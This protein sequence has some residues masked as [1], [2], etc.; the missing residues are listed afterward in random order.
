MPSPR[1]LGLGKKP[2]SMNDPR[3]QNQKSSSGRSS[4]SSPSSSLESESD[5]D[6]EQKIPLMSKQR[7]R[8]FRHWVY[9]RNITSEMRNK[10]YS[11]LREI[12]RL[13]I[14][15]QTTG[16]ITR[17]VPLR[18]ESAVETHRDL[19]MRLDG[20]SSCAVDMAHLA[21]AKNLNKKKRFTHFCGEVPL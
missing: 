19:F 18:P 15:Q 9:R 20:D 11:R 3:M 8:K 1:A 6:T 17:R 5:D 2:I 4:S 12:L 13:N 10:Y 14:L 16:Q 7:E 21:Q